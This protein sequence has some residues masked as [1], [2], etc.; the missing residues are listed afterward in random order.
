MSQTTVHFDSGTEPSMAGKFVAAWGLLGFALLLA[1]GIWR[2]WP[3][4]AGATFEEFSAWHW[5]A[6]GASLIA[7]GY[8]EGY[9]AIHR[10]VIPR[11]RRRAVQLAVGEGLGEGSGRGEGS[12]RGGAHVIY[13]LLAPLYCMG[14]LGAERHLLARS[15]G[16]VTAIVL[17]ILGMRFVPAPWREIILIGVS[18]AL[19]WALLATLVE[20]AR[21]LRDM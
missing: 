21:M 18:A 10:K 13:S 3:M 15:W 4:A 17:M 7:F 20:T 11:L 19:V 8:G 2:L 12:R 1:R 9:R 16:M 14:L 5:A 6:V